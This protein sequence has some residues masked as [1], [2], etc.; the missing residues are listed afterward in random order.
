[1]DHALHSSV[2]CISRVGC[3]ILPDVFTAL[4]LIFHE[5]DNNENVIFIFVFHFH[6]DR[7]LVVGSCFTMF[8]INQTYF[9]TNRKY[10]TF[11]SVP[12]GNDVIFISR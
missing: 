11:P 9:I 12:P 1:M 10:S 7:Y 8:H 6:R 5:N 4:L 3:E 2:E